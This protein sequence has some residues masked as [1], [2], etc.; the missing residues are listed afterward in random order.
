MT[1]PPLV[2]PGPVLLPER[3]ARFA[4][5]LPLP[6]IGA[7]GQRRIASARVLVIGAG[8]LGA[9]VLQY[10]AAAGVG[11]ITVMDDDR[12]ERTNLQR[13]VLHGE[14]DL[15]TPKAESARRA[16]AALDSQVHVT[17][18][19]ERLDPDNALAL[20]R[21][22]DVVL[23]GADNFAT[24]YLVNDAAELTGT[25]VVWGSILRF[26]GQLS[27]FW[28]GRGPMLRDLHPEVP[29]EDSVADCA[30][31]GVFGALCGVVGSAMAVEALKLICGVG[32]P[33]VGRLA[34]Y[35]A[36]AGRWSELRF[37]ID[38]DRPAV[39]DLE[40]VRLRCAVS[41]TGRPDDIS[42]GEVAAR[43]RSAKPGLVV[44]D[45][46]TADER[47]AGSIEG[48]HHVPLDQLLSGGWPV[49]AAAL[50]AEAHDRGD[51]V[52]TCQGGIRSA[53]AIDALTVSAPTGTSL[54][55]LAGGM[56]AYSG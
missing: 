33:L 23:D 38:P 6:G 20:F 35:D 28:P 8:G 54:R 11:H 26:A 40:E 50:G 56:S 49:L 30:T 53:R 14:A 15:G 4:R 7:E 32:E 16:I 3:A 13:Q 2:V 27:V 46:R 5:H 37:G 31:G 9:P 42:A 52:I 21:A 12:V 51:I 41:S 43:L 17:A 45:V 1:L 55:N 24:R 25:P 22:H 34:R 48:S 29:D 10:L 19:V 44:V 18:H 39:T 47:E 36:L